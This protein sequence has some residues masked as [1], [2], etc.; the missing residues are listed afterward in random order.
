ME[1]AR[2]RALLQALALSPDVEQIDR[3]LKSE[4]LERLERMFEFSFPPDLAGFLETGVPRGRGFPDWRG[5]LEDDD[6]ALQRVQS[7]LEWPME[8]AALG[9]ENDDVPALV[10]PPD[11]DPVLALRRLSDLMR[12]A[13]RLVPVRARCYIPDS[14]ALAGNPVFEIWGCDVKLAARD[15]ES[16]MQA[17]C[18]AGMVADQPGSDGERGVDDQPGAAREIEFWSSLLRR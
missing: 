12:A 3:G 5:C 13:P 6:D 7:M 15:L 14:P 17:Q 16:Y 2:H 8:S 18:P 9:L 11:M 10:G 4:E 1:D